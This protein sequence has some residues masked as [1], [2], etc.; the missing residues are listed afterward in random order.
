MWEVHQ[1]LV[2]VGNKKT[3]NKVKTERFVFVFTS[4]I[5]DHE[6]KSKAA[7]GWN[8]LSLRDSMRSTRVK[9]LFLKLKRSPSRWFGHLIGMLSGRLPWRF[10][11][12]VLLYRRPQRTL[13]TCW[14]D[15]HF[16][17]Y[18]GNV[19]RSE[20]VLPSAFL[21][22]INEE[23]CDRVLLLVNCPSC[24]KYTFIC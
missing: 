11:R 14:R 5:Y 12:A 16:P 6:W 7:S 1:L 22:E 10:F 3:K 20:H 18:T 23:E 21:K 17:L 4:F 13:I 2:V 9:L 19:L 24:Q 15:H 8:E